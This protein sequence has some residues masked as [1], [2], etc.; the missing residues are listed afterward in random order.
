MEKK[1][2]LIIIW[3][4]WKEKKNQNA[5]LKFCFYLKIISF[6][7]FFISTNFFPGICGVCWTFFFFWEKKMGSGMFNN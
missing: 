7:F 4:F 3:K 5:E 2:K 6:H 1:E